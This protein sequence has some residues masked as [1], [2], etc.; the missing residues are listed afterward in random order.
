MFN[1]SVI[2]CSYNGE[3][4]IEEQLDSL[5]KQS[6]FINEYIIC[7]D[8]SLDNTCDI[9]E[10]YI[11][12]NPE[13]N[14]KL[15]RNSKNKGVIKNFEFGLKQASG[16]YIAFCDQ[17]DVWLPNKIELSLDK[18]KEMEEI[19]GKNI[20]LLVHTDLIVVDENL[21]IISQSFFKQEGLNVYKDENV[22]KALFLQNNLV[23]CTMLFNKIAKNLS[24][25]FPEHIIM[26]DYWLGLVVACKGKIEFI[27][28]ETIKYR[29]HKENVVG[30]KTYI[31]KN[32]L[33][34]IFNKDYLNKSI[35]SVIIQNKELVNY[36]SGS[37]VKN[38]NWFIE[39]LK[40]IEKNNISRMIKLRIHKHGILRNIILY[41]FFMIRKFDL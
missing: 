35:N 11:E 27:N 25:P 30:A 14:I 38:N 5:K 40:A 39:A 37:L 8:N 41:I 17:D 21:D 24:L 36:K 16:D 2:L 4:Y 28:Q 3:K 18:I 31:S 20:P 33:K 26:H 19:Y 13:L 9:I 1:I 12:K 7:D 15:F 22:L 34:K 6:V 29:Q 10:N 32:S 23:G